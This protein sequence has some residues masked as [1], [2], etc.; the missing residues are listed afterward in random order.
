M[1]GSPVMGSAITRDGA[2]RSGRRP[3]ISRGG[4]TEVISWR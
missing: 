1:T 3:E 2:M 4:T